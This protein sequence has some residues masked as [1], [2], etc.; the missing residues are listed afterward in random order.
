MQESLSLARLSRA[1][2]SGVAIDMKT[3]NALLFTQ[4][5]ITVVVGL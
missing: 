4:F 5:T 1:G 2:V 3:F